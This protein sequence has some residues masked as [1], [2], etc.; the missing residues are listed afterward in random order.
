[1]AII[2]DD[3]TKLVIQGITG[4]QGTYHSQALPVMYAIHIVSVARSRGVTVIGPNCPGIASPG[5]AKVGILPN[6]IFRK[7]N[8]GVVS[9]SGTLTYEIVNGIS[10]RRMGQ[11]TCVGIGGER[12][13]G[14]HLI[15]RLV[16]F[17]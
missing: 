5:K 9:K 1:M 17:S 14:A 13:S 12:G 8:I 6:M 11:S 2:V 10:G 16:G 3:K 15:G 7:G 4:S